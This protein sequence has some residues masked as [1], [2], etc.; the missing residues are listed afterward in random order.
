[1]YPMGTIEIPVYSTTYP[2]KYETI[3]IMA[4]NV[5]GKDLGVQTNLKQIEQMREFI[6]S[7]TKV[8]QLKNYCEIEELM[9]EIPDCSFAP[10][11]KDKNQMYLSNYTKK[12]ILY[13]VYREVLYNEELIRVVY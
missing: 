7:Q 1:M 2:D 11:S 4:K 8:E 3:F 9:S 12:V 5:F 10:P 6:Y 13:V